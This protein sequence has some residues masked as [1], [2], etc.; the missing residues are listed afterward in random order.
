MKNKKQI[1]LFYLMNFLRLLNIVPDEIIG[2]E[3]PD[4]V[5]KFRG[6]KIGVELTGFHKSR[7]GQPRRAIE[8]NWNLLRK[9]IMESVRSNQLLE[10]TFGEI[11]FMTLEIPSKREF[12]LFIDELIR[13]SLY[14]I[15]NGINEISTFAE[16]PLLNRY[17]S[18]FQLEKTGIYIAW[19]W[20]HNVTWV[21][22]S[23][24]E[25]I[26]SI[27]KK[28][29]A[30]YKAQNIDEVWLIIISGHELSQAMG[31][32]LDYKLNNFNKFNS[33]LMQSKYNRVFIYQYML[34]LIY[35]WPGWIKEE[36][37]PRDNP[38][39]HN[40][41]EVRASIAAACQ[42]VGRDHKEVRLVAV[43]KTVDLD[44]IREAVAAG[45]YIF[46]E[47]YLQEARDKI[48]ALGR[49]VSWHLVGHLQTKKAKGAVEL[50][51]LIHAVDR[52]KL[53]RALEAAAARLGKVQNVLV[54]VNQGG[55]DTKS[56]VAPAAAAAL[57]QEVARLPH[58][59]LLGLM[60]MPP[61]FPD[62]EE[63]RPYFRA[64]RELRDRLRGLT[65][66][67]LAEL[68]MGM[69]GDFEV[70]VEEGATLVRVGTAIFGRRR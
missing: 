56:G 51:D 33:L 28:S 58:L 65:G 35:S 39:A 67:S 20:N 14:M 43:S 21:G 15:N 36:V 19:D 23:E 2:D 50:F 53:A 46:G 54:Q 13:I 62:P 29:L 45:Q 1:E 61:W 59:R 22:L 49:P 34:D 16:Y 11:Y 42:K 18:K 30:N 55:E 52:L 17:L 9:S 60:S 27:E 69:S 8:E 25:L 5:L 40:L 66:L 41:T 63:A 37:F 64:L 24:E 68:S 44:R 7:N 4:F 12:R 31:V 6:E 57:V 32:H 26:K 3:A 10:N 38:I 70:A 47:N 48:A